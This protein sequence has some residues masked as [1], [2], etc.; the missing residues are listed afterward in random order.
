MINSGLLIN[1]IV[2]TFPGNYLAIKAEYLINLISK[3]EY[4]G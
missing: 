4:D 1:T 2:N 3:W